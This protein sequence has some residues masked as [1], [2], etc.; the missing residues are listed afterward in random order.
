MRPEANGLGMR[1]EHG[2]HQIRRGKTQRTFPGSFPP[3]LFQ[4]RPIGNIYGWL[5]PVFE[6]EDIL[7][8]SPVQDLLARVFAGK[9]MRVIFFSWHPVP[10]IRM[11]RLIDWP[12][13]A[14]DSPGKQLLLQ[15]QARTLL[16]PSVNPRP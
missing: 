14:L 11:K 15:G 5:I 4:F 7:E 16:E 1:A 12:A 2:L 3:L 8:G 6:G 13:C 9:V 10:N